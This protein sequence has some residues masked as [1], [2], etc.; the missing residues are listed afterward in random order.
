MTVSLIR[1]GATV[2]VLDRSGIQFGR[3]D[4]ID[5]A[6]NYDPWPIQALPVK[7]QANFRSTP[8]RQGPT[9]STPVPNRSNCR[10]VVTP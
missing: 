1:D 6:T 4:E 3:V 2:L 8:R 9:L 5:D 10:W 7:W